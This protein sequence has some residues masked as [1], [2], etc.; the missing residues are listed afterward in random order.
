MEMP[1]SLPVALVAPPRDGEP[2]NGY[3]RN[4]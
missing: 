2:D 3:T 1:L 4:W